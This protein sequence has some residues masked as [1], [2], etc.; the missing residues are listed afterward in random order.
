MSRTY[1]FSVRDAREG[2]VTAVMNGRAKSPTVRV[3]GSA[4]VIVVPDGDPFDGLLP[5]S[6]EG[7]ELLRSEATSDAEPF[8]EKS[9]P[10]REAKEAAAVALDVAVEAIAVEMVDGAMLEVKP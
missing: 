4:V 3:S 2:A 8:A 7:W 6:D 1:V 10:I 9:D 5:G